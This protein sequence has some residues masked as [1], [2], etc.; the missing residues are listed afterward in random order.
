[1]DIACINCII[2]YTI[3]H[4]VNIDLILIVYINA[5]TCSVCL[6]VYAAHTFSV[7]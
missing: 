1:M 6:Q 3:R 2:S 5:N 7:Y 4:T